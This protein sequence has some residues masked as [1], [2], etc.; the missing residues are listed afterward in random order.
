ME[1]K[2]IEG[3]SIFCPICK[4]FIVHSVTTNCEHTFCEVCLTDYMLYIDECPECLA[5]IRSQRVS[6]NILLDNLVADY[7]RKYE[8]ND[9]A[10]Y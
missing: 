7:I 4:D 9:L 2:D 1:C 5:R 3:I 10:N 8:P 6:N